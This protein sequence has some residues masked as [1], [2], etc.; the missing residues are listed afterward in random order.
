M[1]LEILSIAFLTKIAWHDIHTHMI[2]NSDLVITG[3]ILLLLYWRNWFISLVNFCIY[4]VLYILSRGKLG[5]GDLKLSI[6]SA[7]SLSSVSQLMH[8]IT[9]TWLIGGV[10]ALSKP[11]TCIPFAPFMILGTYLAKFS[12]P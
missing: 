2:R 5:E 6:I 4:F 3:S 12:I 9:A 1:I 11:R 7:I 10:F 8:A